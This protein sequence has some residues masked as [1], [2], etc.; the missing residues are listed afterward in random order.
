[1]ATTAIAPSNGA[2]PK[3]TT[4]HYKPLKEPV[5][6]LARGKSSRGIGVP[7]LST[8]NDEE[9][10]KDLQAIDK[11]SLMAQ[12]YSSQLHSHLNNI[13]GNAPQSYDPSEVVLQQ[14]QSYR[15]YKQKSEKLQPAKPA[16]APEEERKVIAQKKKLANAEAT[17]ELLETQ[18][19]SLRAHYVSASQRLATSRLGTDAVTKA[20]H[21]L[22]ERRATSMAFRRVRLAIAREVL[23]VLRARNKAGTE[24]PAKG[25]KPSK[26][27]AAAAAD[28]AMD[29]DGN[30]NLSE[31]W[32]KVEKGLL[33]AELA[34]SD[35]SLEVSCLSA[36]G[37]G[38]NG[39]SK[40][41]GGKGDGKRGNK[42][43]KAQVALSQGG[44]RNSVITWENSPLPST[45]HG[46][47][48]LLS[49]LGATPDKTAAASYGGIF[50]SSDKELTWLEVG[51]PRSMN[52]RED[53][54]ESLVFIKEECSKMRQR[55]VDLRRETMELQRKTVL[56]RREGEKINAN[57]TM[58][59]TETEA[60]LGR[61]HLVLETPEAKEASK[62]LRDRE[63]MMERKQREAEEQRAAEEDTESQN[64]DDGSDE[65]G[66]AGANGG[67]EAGG[68]DSGEDAKNSNIGG[69]G[70]LI[71]G[72]EGVLGDAATSNGGEAEGSSEEGAAA[73]GDTQG[74]RM[75]AEGGADEGEIEGG[76][77]GEAAESDASV[78]EAATGK[79]KGRGR[80]RGRGRG[81]KRGPAPGGAAAKR[82]RR[83]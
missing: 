7:Y 52:V 10:T 41:K 18:Y 19:M 13:N 47:P 9:I 50:G 64:E 59:R 45:P 81:K 73:D 78:T 69:L 70:N 37:V 34:C 25:K 15:K 36:H 82:A 76:A 53:E 54:S 11:F 28:D 72:A 58:Y 8:L 43:L 63:E 39:G 26:A 40:A 30:G 33:E 35:E 31:C 75:D 16:L 66:S 46:L 60:V 79:G 12:N 80:G 68:V 38:G 4:F 51:M 22:V 55:T 56:Q 62:T 77:L 42:S 49:V 83:R 48:L 5:K 74:V 23:G 65:D 1:M 20:L 6:G 17:R 71:T 67:G 61:H 32:D 27:A 24:K 2:A 21:G 29:V 14:E 44:Q 57:I 3:S